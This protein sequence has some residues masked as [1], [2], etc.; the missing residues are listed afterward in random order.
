MVAVICYSATRQIA[1]GMKLRKKFITK[2]EERNPFDFSL[3]RHTR[4]PVVILTDV[5]EHDQHIVR[6]NSRPTSTHPKC[7]Y[8]SAETIHQAQLKAKLAQSPQCIH[9]IFLY[10]LVILCSASVLDSISLL[11]DLPNDCKQ[12]KNASTKNIADE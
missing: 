8:L 4:S 2:Y 7:S 12:L 1:D 3:N 6:G 10:E 5:A 11:T 9:Y